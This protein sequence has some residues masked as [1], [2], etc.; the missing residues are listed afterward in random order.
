MSRVRSALI[1]SAVALGVASTAAGTL[2]LTGSNH[3]P[4]PAPTARAEEV[5]PQSLNYD[6]RVSLAPL[7]KALGPT[8]VHLEVE[9]DVAS[10][11]DALTQRMQPFLQ[12]PEGFNPPQTQSGEGSGFIIS[13]D[14]LVLTNNHVVEGADR[15]TVRLDDERSFEASVLGT[16]PRTDVALVQLEGASDLPSAVLGSSEALEVGDWVVAIGNPF[17]LDHSV[18]AGILSGKGRDLG[19]GPYDAF[20]QTDASINPGNSGG[21]LFNLKGE[22]VGINTAIIGQGIGFAVPI[23]MVAGMVEE[24]RT[25]GRV[26]RGWMGVGLRPLDESLSAELGVP[27]GS[28]VVLG[29]IYPGTPAA[30]A[31]LR[32]GDVLTTLDGA[33][34][35]DSAAVVR[36]IGSRKPGDVVKLGVVRDGRDR[37]IKVSLGD[38]PEEGDLRAGRWRAAP[39]ED[40]PSALDNSLDALGIAAQSA[41]E[42]GLRGPDARGVVIT[43]IDRDSPAAAAL[44]PGDRVLF[45]NGRAV[46]DV[47]DL[48]RGLSGSEGRALL[49]VDRGDTQVLVDVP[50]TD[51]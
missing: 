32:A 27:S 42:L 14:G 36:A 21:P 35:G 4:V 11:L 50:L 25:D 10:P 29:Q 51:D 33:P 31:G 3:A 46:R 37:T 20:L 2:A 1:L 30:D 24:L 48:A 39:D 49:V 26:A 34:V 22:V 15:V 19:A 5:P 44:Q 13:P 16:D 12:M 45:V 41:R 43:R 17:G 6:P 18:S 8:V 47:S 40:A 9:K 28:G 7:V 38:R 23:D